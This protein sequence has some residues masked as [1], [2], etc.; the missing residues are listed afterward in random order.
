MK[1]QILVEMLFL[2]LSRK[3]VT[4]KDMMERFDLPRR[5]V[6]RY[7]DTLC[8]ANIP[9]T[10]NYGRKGGF[11]IPPQ[12][13]LDASLFLK[14]DFLKLEEVFDEFLKNHPSDKAASALFQRLLA[15]KDR[16]DGE[17]KG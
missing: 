6:F 9:I 3:R 13:K 8:L 7:I 2:L 16:P 4:I 5:T 11:F 14:D 17:S 1:Y 15:L 10:V 12:F